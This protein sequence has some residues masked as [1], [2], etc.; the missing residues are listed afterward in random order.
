F[1]P[2]GSYSEPIA[3][4]WRDLETLYGYEGVVTGGSRTRL[5]SS[6][7]GRGAATGKFRGMSYGVD[8]RAEKVYQ[9]VKKDPSLLNPAV[10][11]RFTFAASKAILV[12][13]LGSEQEAIDVMSAHP[14]ILREGEALESA[15]ANQIKL[16]AMSRQ[17]MPS[18][19]LL[20]T[21]AVLFNVL[22]V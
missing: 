7:L 5:D 8:R 12:E 13:K 15:S 11:N 21:T 18:L 20:S 1:N 6:R 3:T 9:A 16:S 14:S 22:A 2:G 10:S 4:L 19:A 17:A